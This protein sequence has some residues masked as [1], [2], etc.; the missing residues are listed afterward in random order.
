MDKPLNRTYIEPKPDTPEVRP[1]IC[2]ECGEDK[3]ILVGMG[4]TPNYCAS[5][6]HSWV[7]SKDSDKDVKPVISD[8]SESVIFKSPE[9]LLTL[10][11]KP[12]GFEQRLDAAITEAIKKH[13]AENR[14]CQSCRQTTK[15]DITGNSFS[16]QRCGSVKYPPTQLAKAGYKKPNY[17]DIT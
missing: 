10:N 7:S 3:D 15:H 9:V 2:P 13:T 12:S 1:L 11:Q 4:D 17:Y 16:C 8:I 14:Y 6:N 5:C